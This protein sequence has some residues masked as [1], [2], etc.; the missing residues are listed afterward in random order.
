MLVGAISQDIVK[1]ILAS[2]IRTARVPAAT[3]EGLFLWRVGY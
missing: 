1:E 2:K 3:P